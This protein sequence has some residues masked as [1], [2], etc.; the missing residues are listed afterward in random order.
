MPRVS[1]IIPARDPR[2]EHLERSVSSALNQTLATIEVVIVDDGSDQAGAALVDSVARTDPRIR[3]LHQVNGGVSAARNAGRVAA[4]GEF[5]AFLDVDDYLASDF[6]SSALG[7]AEAL[8][9]GVVFGGITVRS[10]GGSAVWAPSLSQTGGARLLSSDEVHV[11][12]GNTLAASPPFLVDYSELAFTNVGGALYRVSATRDLLFPAGVRHGEDRLF[13]VAALSSAG[14]IAVSAA[15][16]YTYDRTHQSGVTSD[17]TAR[18]VWELRATIEAFSAAGGI[19]IANRHLPLEIRQGAAVGVLNYLKLAVLASAVSAEPN[20]GRSLVELVE[21]PAAQ[22]AL[23]YLPPV[24]LR[25][26]MLALLIRPGL[27]R[28]VVLLAKARRA[29]CSLTAGRVRR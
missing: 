29:F 7:L 23:R 5:I 14:S 15:R 26:R 24:G 8:D 11:A 13:N 21:L 19:S 3:V 6:T 17:F 22:Q 1:V 28:I 2:P 27:V 25:D 10:V 18:R 9:A 16:W 4:R 20:G 12:C